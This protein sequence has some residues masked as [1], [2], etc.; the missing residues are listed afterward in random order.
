MLF[1]ALFILKVARSIVAILV[2]EGVLKECHLRAWTSTISQVVTLVLILRNFA[3]YGP[4]L[5]R[6]TPLRFQHEMMLTLVG[7]QLPRLVRATR[8]LL[9]GD[10][11]FGSAADRSVC[12][13]RYVIPHSSIWGVG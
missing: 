7:L 4:S 13:N 5:S 9:S 10:G 2:S 11:T 1:L 8:A 3:A 12:S 6:R